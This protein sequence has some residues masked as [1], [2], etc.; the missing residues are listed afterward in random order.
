MRRS[1]VPARLWRL[2]GVPCRRLA[3]CP[4]T[5]VAGS[6][7]APIVLPRDAPSRTASGPQRGAT[8]T[9]VIQRTASGARDE[10]LTPAGW[11]RGLAA[12]FPPV[13]LLEGLGWD[14]DRAGWGRG[15]ISLGWDEM[16]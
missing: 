5:A 4:G 9:E 2:L 13:L 3:A 12:P 14:G 1:W 16:R 8:A 6:T 7:P 15:G 10:A 11:A